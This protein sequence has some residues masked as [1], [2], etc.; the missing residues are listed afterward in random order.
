MSLKIGNLAIAKPDALERR[1]GLGLRAV[2]LFLNSDVYERLVSAQL[3]RGSLCPYSF[4]M[5]HFRQLVTTVDRQCG[6]AATSIKL[7]VLTS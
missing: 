1:S 3:F 6:D 2:S 7:K 5:L 4:N